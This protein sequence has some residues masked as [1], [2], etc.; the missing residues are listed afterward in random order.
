MDDIKNLNEQE[1]VY[2][3][4]KLAKKENLSQEELVLQK[5]LRNEYISRV[6]KNLKSHLDN[7]KPQNT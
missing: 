7:I 1:L 3:I 4:N 2:E 5:I 6:K